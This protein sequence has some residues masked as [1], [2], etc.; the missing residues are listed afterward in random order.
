[1]F[2]S[3]ETWALIEKW[4]NAAFAFYFSLAIYDWL[5]DRAKKIAAW[6]KKRREAR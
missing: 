1:M 2:G 6:R 5:E 4:G 3:P